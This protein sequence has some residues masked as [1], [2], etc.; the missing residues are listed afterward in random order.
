MFLNVSMIDRSTRLG[1]SN[2]CIPESPIF[3]GIGGRASERFGLL[4]VEGGQVHVLHLHQQLS[5][6]QL[7]ANIVD[8]GGQRFVMWLDQINREADIFKVVRVPGDTQRTGDA[9]NPGEEPLQFCRHLARTRQVRQTHA[10]TRSQHAGEC[11]ASRPFVRKGAEGALADHGIKLVIGKREALCIALL[12]A[13]QVGDAS[14]FG[15]ASRLS[16][17]ILSELD[18]E[19]LVLPLSVVDNSAFSPTRLTF[20]FDP[21]YSSFPEGNFLSPHNKPRGFV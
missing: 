9:G 14:S 8:H 19:H 7:R 21:A 2:E 5:R 15:Y 13:D 12:E 3:H 16:H 20:P 18:T 11:S 6:E 17:R 4:K 10:A 1:G